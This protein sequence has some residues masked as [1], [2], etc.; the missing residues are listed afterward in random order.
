MKA[1]VLYKLVTN[2]DYFGGMSIETQKTASE[3][4]PI[5]RYATLDSPVSFSNGL[6]QLPNSGIFLRF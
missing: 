3:Q 6:D 2:V 1:P 5:I 4:N